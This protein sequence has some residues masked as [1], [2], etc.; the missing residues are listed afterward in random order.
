VSDAEARSILGYVQA[1][2]P[3]PPRLRA[4]LPH[5]EQD[6]KRCAECHRKINPTIVAQFE[7]SA[8]GRAGVQNPRVQLA[9]SQITCAACHGTNHDDIMA[10]K[11]RVP[12][13]ACG[14]CHPQIYKEAVA[15]AGHSY[16]PG[17][18]G[19]GINWERNVGVTMGPGLPATT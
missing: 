13:T 5:G 15:D 9:Q 19:L 3:P 14:A 16:G 17:P 1:V 11:G 10:S 6:Q 8:M 2:P 12:E 7:T 18:G 4:D